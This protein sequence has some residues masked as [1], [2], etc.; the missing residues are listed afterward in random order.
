[1]LIPLQ[2]RII[3]YTLLLNMEKKISKINYNGVDY[4]LAVDREIVK[5]LADLG[6]GSDNPIF[7]GIMDAADIDKPITYGYLTNLM[8][9]D[10]RNNKAFANTTMPITVRTKFEDAGG[11][12]L[13]IL[14]PFNHPNLYMLSIPAQQFTDWDDDYTEVNIDFPSG[15]KPYKLFM[16][17]NTLYRS[18]VPVT[19]TF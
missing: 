7:V 6:D 8:E 12:R 11:K 13:F 2:Y 4:S 14:V 3:H 17:G 1:M 16:F 9:K 5:E 18:S 15:D 19:Y 10:N